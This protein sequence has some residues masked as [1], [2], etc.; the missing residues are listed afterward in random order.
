MPVQPMHSA[1]QRHVENTAFK[2]T[3]KLARILKTDSCMFGKSCVVIVV[4]IVV[5]IV[6]EMFSQRRGQ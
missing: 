6:V 4:A 5:A 2:N 3:Q 1:L